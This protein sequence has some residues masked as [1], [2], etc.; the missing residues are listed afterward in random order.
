[1]KLSMRKIDNVL[2]SAG[3]ILADDEI[4]INAAVVEYLSGSGKINCLRFRYRSNQ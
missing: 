3:S 2:Y 1:M 4:E